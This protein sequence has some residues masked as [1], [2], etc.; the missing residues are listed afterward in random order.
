MRGFMNL[1]GGQKMRTTTYPKVLSVVS[2][3]GGVKFRRKKSAASAAG[4]VPTPGNY[5]NE[6]V[7][8]FSVEVRAACSRRRRFRILCKVHI[9][10][11]ML[12]NF[13]TCACVCIQVVQLL[14][15]IATLACVDG[16]FMLP[17]RG[18][19]RVSRQTK[20]LVLAGGR[21]VGGRTRQYCYECRLSHD[22][23]RDGRV[24][25]PLEHGVF[26]FLDRRSGRR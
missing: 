18:P 26:D 20:G 9:K 16:R 17:R 22:G 1:F 4:D 3:F 14:P 23:T 6:R 19:T 7:D 8:L 25:W 10:H 15:A 24:H 13:R 2:V 11:I 5:Y 12:N 21:S